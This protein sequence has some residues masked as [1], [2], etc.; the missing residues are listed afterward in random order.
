MH[1][2]TTWDH[3]AKAFDFVELPN[4]Q[5]SI[6]RCLT[7][8]K[9][10]RG[11]LCSCETIEGKSVSIA[12]DVVFADTIRIRMHPDHIEEKTTEM[13]DG[14]IS[15]FSIP[16]WK[17]TEYQKPLSENGLGK[18]SQQ[19]LILKTE[20]LEVR[21]QLYPWQ[22]SIL[23]ADT[24]D[25]D[26]RK[27]NFADAS[28]LNYGCCKSDNSS[29]GEAGEHES[30]KREAF[31]EQKF[32]DRCFGPFYESA[33]MGYDPDFKGRLCA[34]DSIAVRPGE[35]IYGLGE[36]FT[37]M[38]KWGQRIDI[39]AMDAGSVNAHRSYKAMPFLLSSA[40]YGLFVHTS[41]PSVFKICSESGS[42]YTF[43]IA[44][45]R[46]DYFVIRG[47][48][49]SSI[50]RR[51]AQ[52]TGF[53]PVPP[54][55]SFGM[56][57]S[58]CAYVNQEEVESAAEGMRER[59][60]PFDVISIDPWWQGEAP[61]CSYRW[62]ESAFPDHAEMLHRL[63]E[64]GVHTCLWITPY[65]PAG[66]E[67]Y[68]EGIQRGYFIRDENGRPAPVLEA[69]AGDEL[70]GIDFT[71]PEQTAWFQSKLERLLEEGVSVFKTDFGEQAPV[72]ACYADG[73]SGLEMHN[74]YPL[75]YNKAVFEL[76]KKKTGRGIT[77]GRSGYIG[78]QR[79]PVQWGGDSYASFSQMHGQ[80]RGLLS[81]GL[82]GVPFCSHDIG[83]FDY[84]PE[85]FDL[86]TEGIYA[87]QAAQARLDTTKGESSEEAPNLAPDNLRD[88]APDPTIYIRWMQFGV[89][90]SH[91]RSHG[92]RFHEPW[93]YGKTAERISRKY[94]E[95]R[96]Q[97]LP[98]IYSQAVHSSRTALPMVRPMLL[99]FQ[100]DPTTWQLETQYL[101]GK[102]LLAAPVFNHSGTVRVYFP[103]GAWCD[104]WNDE[105]IEGPCW[106]NIRADLETYPLWIR[107][108]SVIPMGPVMQY[109]SEKPMDPLTVVCFRPEA[110]SEHII[111]DEPKE[112][113]GP[114]KTVSITI[115]SDI[116]KNLQTTGDAESLQDRIRR[117]VSISGAPG[118][119]IL[120]IRGLKA[121]KAETRSTGS[122]G[123]T[124][125]AETPG[126]KGTSSTS[127]T[128]V[129]E[130]SAGAG[131]AYQRLNIS[132]C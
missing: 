61:W 20:V 102:N 96:Y 29:R 24:E 110:G 4:P 79:Y 58:R 120:E 34:R 66:T 89:F 64:Q 42:A 44:D 55:W 25:N 53:A 48:Q 90:S 115:A 39:W 117:N 111:Y 108:G 41:F 130:E 65:V 50:L 100:D 106:K 60:L 71:D 107:E 123:S 97:L 6:R 47:K 99:D 75:L 81:Y 57:L 119:V 93:E 94:L 126:P 1:N 98:Y 91:A 85:R 113:D 45:D 128:S 124:G 46:L 92:K 11:L 21:L 49:H 101:F 33:P 67:L 56:W 77:W 5:M 22:I 36:R 23:D 52:L 73:R 127:E 87:S 7:W 54:K 112:S 28:A 86:I 17:L 103:E 72:D 14:S 63:R 30:V 74:L 82:S 131:L 132:P 83:G 18:G 37:K 104:F 40:G 10:E 88:T 27:Q 121:G 109:V 118:K 80:L 59:G 62:D 35:S 13:L 95:L 122:S 9:N 43:E 114:V 15:R 32:A 8:E 105:I 69:F 26:L 3:I 116:L 84:E 70:A 19:M 51:Y 38:D 31:F 2:P 125:I 76:V 16:K 129:H 12:V 68:Q 78:S